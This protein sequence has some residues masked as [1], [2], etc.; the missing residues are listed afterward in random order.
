MKY[1]KKIKKREPT[2]R[3]IIGLDGIEKNGKTHFALTAPG[4]ICII[5]MD[6]GLEGVVDKFIGEKEIHHVAFNKRE[7]TNPAQWAKMWDN[8]IRA[9]TEALTDKAI[10]TI[11]V[12]TATE[13]WELV[14]LARF[15]KLTQVMPHHYGPV[16]EEFRNVI[17]DAYNYDKNVILLHK[18]KPKYVNDKRT[19]DIERAGFGDTGY[20]VQANMVS[21]CDKHGSFGITIRDCRHNPELK[22]MDIPEPLNTFPNVASMILPET[23]PEDW[24]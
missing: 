22:G 20:L 15:G 9:Y 19:N 3:L 24:E 4:P 21:W 2:K 14:R 18:M 6:I 5:D 7:A 23:E 17:R 10:K 13:V 11:I 8:V 16:N 12:D 1:F